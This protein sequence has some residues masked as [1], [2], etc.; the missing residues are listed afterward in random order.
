VSYRVL[1]SESALERVTEFLDFIAEESPAAAKRVIED[2]R[3]RVGLL[4]DQ[5]RM[6]RPLLEGIDPDLRRLIVG[7]YVVVYRI[8][9]NRRIID[10]V[11][12]RHSRERS[13][14]QEGV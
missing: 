5:P 10:I 8:Q 9:E 13:L 1:W 7:K 14:P 11:A 12:V 2:L 4:A 6:G 3:Q